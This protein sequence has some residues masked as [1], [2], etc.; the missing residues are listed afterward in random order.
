M[1]LEEAAGKL[2]NAIVGV[3]PG[4]YRPRGEEESVQS[5][6]ER[7]AKLDH[8]NKI[9]RLL[10]EFGKACRCGMTEPE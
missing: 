1:G 6:A 10:I 5:H 8:R 4:T 2:A 9:K 3:D 7:R